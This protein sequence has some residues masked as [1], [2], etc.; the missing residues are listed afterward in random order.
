MTPACL[1]DIGGSIQEAAIEAAKTQQGSSGGIPV[2][3]AI[4]STRDAGRAAEAGADGVVLNAASISSESAADQVNF[5]CFSNI[6]KYETLFSSS[7]LYVS[8]CRLYCQMYATYF[9]R[10]SA[11][12][13]SLACSRKLPLMGSIELC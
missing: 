5:L 9:F 6:H 2:A 12:C 7:D 13:H 4:P 8:H 11:E 10:R 3:V 1:Q